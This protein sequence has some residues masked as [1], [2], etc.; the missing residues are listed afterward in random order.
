M[1][2]SE[3]VATLDL[4]EGISAPDG[5]QVYLFPRLSERRSDAG[6]YTVDFKLRFYVGGNL[7]L[8]LDL[9]TVLELSEL[10][11]LADLPS[12]WEEVRVRASQD[13]M[14]FIDAYL[15]VATIQILKEVRVHVRLDGDRCAEFWF[16]WARKSLTA[17]CEIREAEK[18]LKID[19]E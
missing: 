2:K 15:E 8:E 16:D 10:P 1:P 11:N 12:A 5:G 6:S 9:D 3:P 4:A 17:S 14:D 18:F 19:G 13:D 7:V